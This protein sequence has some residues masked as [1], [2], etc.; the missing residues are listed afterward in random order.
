[1]HMSALTYICVYPPTYFAAQ[2][3]GYNDSCFNVQLVF[4]SSRI[5]IYYYQR[6]LEAFLFCPGFMLS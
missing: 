5:S 2:H 4:S 3:K 1:M 6:D